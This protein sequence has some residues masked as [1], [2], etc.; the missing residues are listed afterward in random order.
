MDMKWQRTEEQRET[1]KPKNKRVHVQLK[2]TFDKQ[3]RMWHSFASFA[4]RHGDK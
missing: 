3:M 4:S 2:N 1:E